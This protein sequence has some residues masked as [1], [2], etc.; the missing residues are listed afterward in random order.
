MKNS[1]TLIWALVV[2]GGCGVE[3]SDDD[4]RAP[5]HGE[6]AASAYR[7]EAQEALI[8]SVEFQLADRHGEKHKG[9]AVVSRNIARNADLLFRDAEALR[10]GDMPRLRGQAPQPSLGSFEERLAAAQR[11]VEEAARIGGPDA[12]LVNIV[13]EDPGIGWAG[14]MRSP[15]ELLRTSK[16]RATYDEWLN[17]FAIN[18]SA[19]STS[20]YCGGRGNGSGYVSSNSTAQDTEIA[21]YENGPWPNGNVVG[22]VWV[23]DPGQYYGPEEDGGSWF[24]TLSSQKTSGFALVFSRLICF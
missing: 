12:T 10:P 1:A 20:Y 17:T 16:T 9:V 15:K 2:L 22:S 4:A 11:R 14:G 18:T 23:R 7:S 5:V 13:F 19:H 3:R 8:A 24:Y 21:L 6:P